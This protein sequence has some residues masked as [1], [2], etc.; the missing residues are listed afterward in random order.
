MKCPTL[1]ALFFAASIALA[2]AVPARNY[3]YDDEYPESRHLTVG[4]PV[5]LASAPFYYQSRHLELDELPDRA[6]KY[7]IVKRKKRPG[8]PAPQG[9]S[10]EDD[11]AADDDESNESSEEDEEEDDENAGEDHEEESADVPPWEDLFPEDDKNTGC[12]GNLTILYA[13]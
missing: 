4:R 1:S 7:Q 3:Y 5:S 10:D 11:D 2:I 8:A 12:K 13:F 9:G 6:R